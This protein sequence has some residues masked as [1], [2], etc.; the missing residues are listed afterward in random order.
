LSHFGMKKDMYYIFLHRIMYGIICV[1]M[2][3]IE[4]TNYVCFD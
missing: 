1:F 4:M 3:V 2:N